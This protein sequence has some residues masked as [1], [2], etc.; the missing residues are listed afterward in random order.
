MKRD[1]LIE[2]LLKLH[3]DT[4]IEALDE[5]GIPSTEI[6]LSKRNI[7]NWDHKLK[8][9]VTVASLVIKGDRWS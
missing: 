9:P 2:E 4:E 3:P 1:V 8:M 7:T 6:V 5:V